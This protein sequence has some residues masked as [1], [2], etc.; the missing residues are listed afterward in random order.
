[1]GQDEKWAGQ[2][3]CYNWGRDKNLLFTGLQMQMGEYTAAWSV[4]NLN[5][6]LKSM[7]LEGWIAHM[8]RGL[9]SSDG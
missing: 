9:D 6:F 7:V 3:E 2:S 8:V 1:M 4:I 5:D